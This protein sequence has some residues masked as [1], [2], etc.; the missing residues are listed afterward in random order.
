MRMLICDDDSVLRR[1]VGGVARAAGHEVVA[2]SDNARDALDLAE[3]FAPDAIILDLALAFGTGAQVMEGLKER[4][5]AIHVLVF[6]AF[7][8]DRAALLEAGATVV[9]EKPDFDG[10]EQVLRAWTDLPGTGRER[11]RDGLPRL[12]PNST[13][14][15]PGGLEPDRDFYAALGAALAGDALMVVSIETHGVLVGRDGPH[16]AADWLMELGRITR[17][18]IR[19]QDRMACFDGRH[20]HVLLVGGGAR[21]PERV[22]ERLRELWGEI[23]GE[24]LT[25]SWAVHADDIS[26][27][28]LLHWASPAPA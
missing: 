24:P 11:R 22:Y 3:R 19:A 18:T 17:A 16:V 25:S 26:I 8:S 4:G 5:L 13:S 12:L 6:S 21:G 7:A 27:E 9:I 1:V 15:S 28:Q 20:L 23:S 14:R 2:E 10:L